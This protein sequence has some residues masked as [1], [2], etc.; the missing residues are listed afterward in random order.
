MGGTHRGDSAGSRLVV[1]QAPERHHVVGLLWKTE[2]SKTRRK[3]H[4]ETVSYSIW[5]KHNQPPGRRRLL[6]H[7]VSLQVLRLPWMC[8]LGGKSYRL[9]GGADQGEV[10]GEHFGSG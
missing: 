4:K 2:R 3:S 10:Q 1:F 6:I 5:K 9:P 8:S 7:P